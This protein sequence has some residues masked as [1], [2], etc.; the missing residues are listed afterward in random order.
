MGN[1]ESNTNLKTILVVEDDPSILKVLRRIL[2]TEGYRVLGAG[3]G[4][5]A[6]ALMTE[7]PDLVLQ[8][9]VLPDITGYDL[10]SKLRAHSEDASL[11]I[12]ALSGYMEKPDGPWDTS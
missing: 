10:V 2:E 6:V 4:K 5:D 11:P 9:L 3:N 7:K 8:D 12:L 1:P